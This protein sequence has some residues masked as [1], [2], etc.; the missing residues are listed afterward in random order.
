MDKIISNNDLADK[1]SDMHSDILRIYSDL[2]K[3]DV[4][5]HDFDRGVS[6]FPTAFRMIRSNIGWVFWIMIIG[7]IIT[8]VAL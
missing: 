3:L 7:F 2:D 8:W 4:F 1:L 6:K 5:I